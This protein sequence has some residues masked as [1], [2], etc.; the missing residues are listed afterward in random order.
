MPVVQ[1]Y[2]SL[3]AHV[4][5]NAFI[6]VTLILAFV[7]APRIPD[8]QVRFGDQPASTTM[9]SVVCMLE[10]HWST[11][12]KLVRTTR[13]TPRPPG[14]MVARQGFGAAQRIME[15]FTPPTRTAILTAQV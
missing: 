1:M 2:N 15:F 13:N 7:E 10:H 11:L 9:I 12:S 14:Q 8:S 4:V 6:F 5:F 3:T